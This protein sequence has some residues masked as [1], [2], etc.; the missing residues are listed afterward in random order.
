MLSAKGDPEAPLTERELTDKFREPGRRHTVRD[1][2][3]ELVKPVTGLATGGPCA[4]CSRSATDASRRPDAPRSGRSGRGSAM[5]RSTGTP[6][7]R[8]GA[9]ADAGRGRRRGGVLRDGVESRSRYG[10]LLLALVLVLVALPPR[11]LATDRFVTTDELFWVGRSAAFGRAIETGQLG[12]TFQTGHP[13]VT[14]M[15]TAWLGMG[16]TP[17][18]RSGTVAA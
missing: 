3:D 4:G 5:Q 7:S 16:P 6:P 14:T 10:P 17:G 9:L 8:P 11:L 1:R 18:P 12:Q 15:W 2:G 13:G